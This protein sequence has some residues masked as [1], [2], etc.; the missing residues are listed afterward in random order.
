MDRS[1]ELKQ[2]FVEALGLDPGVDTG[3][4]V[5]GQTAGW[6]STAH[7][8]L[9]AGIENHFDIMLDTQ[10]LIDLSSFGKATEILVKYGVTFDA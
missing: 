5:Y 3:T 9:V 4:I 6:D 8:G 1:A 2:V 7:M 10:D